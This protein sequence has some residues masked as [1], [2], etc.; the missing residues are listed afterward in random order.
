MLYGAGR[1]PRGAI[2]I[3]TREGTN[4]LHGALFGVVRNRRV[5]ARNYFDPGKGAYTRA[6]S[7]RSISRLR[8]P[9]DLLL[10][11][12]EVN[13]FENTSSSDAGII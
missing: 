5:Q 9:L 1:S 12:A 4:E 13:G 2:N 3:V 10:P 7:G 11:L 8:R 6:Q